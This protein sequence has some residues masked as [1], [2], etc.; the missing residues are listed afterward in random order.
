MKFSQDNVG[1]ERT[2][3]KILFFMTATF[4]PSFGNNQWFTSWAGRCGGATEPRTAISSLPHSSYCLSCDWGVSV[5][6]VWVPLWTQFQFWFW[7]FFKPNPLS[8]NFPLPPL[9]FFLDLEYFGFWGPDATPVS[10][11][12]GW[13]LLSL[14][15]DLWPHVLF[16][17]CLTWGRLMEIALWPTLEPLHLC[18][19][20][21]SWYFHNCMV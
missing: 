9:A 19:D 15:V 6:L 1:G 4:P 20:A 7:V 10:A 2:R 8:P 21:Y 18:I 12:R 16:L 3:I 14:G 13:M 11:H 17:V 5:W